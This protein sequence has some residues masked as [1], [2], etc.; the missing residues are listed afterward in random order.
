[1]KY[2]SKLF[3]CTGIV[4]ILATGCDTKQLHQLNL[5]P[6]AVDLVNLN[7]MFSPVQLASAAGGGSGDNRYTD[8]RVNIGMCSYAIQHLANGGFGGI[9]PGDT[10]TD[11]FETAEA[12]FQF[13]YGD[14]LPKLYEII[15]QTSDGGYDAGNKQNLKDAARI[16]RAFLFARVTDYYGSVPYTE[17]EQAATGVYFPKYDKQK[18]IYAALLK[19]LDEAAADLNVSRLDEGF[20]A[21][22]LYFNGDIAKW[23]RWAYS[24]MVRMAMKISNVDA[25]NANTYIA[26]AVSGGVFLSNSDNVW[27]PMSTGPS[28]W[29]NQNG[30]SRAFYPGDGG[31]PTYLSKTLVDYLKGPNAGSVAD[32]DPRLMVISGGVGNWSVPAGAST[33]TPYGGSSFGLDPLNQ[34]GMPNGLSPST[35][36]SQEGVKNPDT[37]YSKINIKMLDLDDPYM[38]M[39]YGEVELLLAEASERGLGGLSPAGAAGHYVNG[40]KASMQMYVAY[41]ATLKISDATADAYLAANPYQPGANGLKMIGSQLWVNHFLNWYEAWG[42]WRRTN[43]PALVAVN[44]PG[45]V[46]A[47]TIPQRLKYPNREVSGNPNFTATATKPNTYVTKVWWAGGPE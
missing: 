8:W 5:N 37:V 14:E 25:A 18:D 41:D 4:T 39:N 3:I 28:V 9:A 27:C 7:F 12:E 15:K 45:N 6:Q 24:L 35:L 22:D 1:M 32:D 40:V 21:A 30:I 43:I 33:W 19:E 46:T 26:K 34:R 13:I 11:N 10:Y 23:K 44:Y 42:D 29:T 2:L 36:K 16:M 31:Q 38:M 47:A 20:G 17:A